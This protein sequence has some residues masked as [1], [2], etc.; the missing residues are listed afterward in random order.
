M[1]RI[2]GGACQLAIGYVYRSVECGSA[3]EECAM[4]PN[5]LSLRTCLQLGQRCFPWA[6]DAVL[7]TYLCVNLSPTI[8]TAKCLQDI[9]N[10]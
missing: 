7:G 6:S 4:E 2:L 3:T 10:S 9:R 8:G 5:V 1:N